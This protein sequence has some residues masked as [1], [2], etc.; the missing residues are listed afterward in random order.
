MLS[1]A[2]TVIG[3]LPV[4]VGV[5]ARTPA[6]ENVTPFGNVLAVLKVTE[7]VPPDCEKLWLNAAPAVPVVIAGGVTVMV[8][9]L[10][11]SV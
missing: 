9:Q 10:M 4:C 2:V 5:P 6:D 8:P 1:V 7:P 3:K 11:V